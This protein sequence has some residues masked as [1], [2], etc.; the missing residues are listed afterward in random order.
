V[1]P[2]VNIRV[3]R[4]KADLERLGQSLASQAAKDFISE[5]AA[6]RGDPSRDAILCQARQ[7]EQEILPQKWLSPRNEDIFGT[8]L[9]GFPG[10]LQRLRRC[11]FVVTCGPRIGEA[12]GASEVAGI[13]HV[14]EK[15]FEG[16]WGH[17]FPEACVS[18]PELEL[19]VQHAVRPLCPTERRSP[20]KAHPKHRGHSREKIRLPSVRS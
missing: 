6:V 8:R 2:G 4:V 16:R 15:G 1:N 9:V 20:R 13:G 7:N 5:E 19:D 17:P 10:K 3:C 12:D 14:P 11:Q 18:G